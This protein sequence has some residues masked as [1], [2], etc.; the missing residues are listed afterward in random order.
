[1]AADHTLNG[2]HF[3]AVGYGV[4][5]P[6]PGG[7]PMTFPFTNDRWRA[8]SDFNA[9][10]KVWLRL[11]QNSATGNGGT[12]YGDS[13]GPNF[14]GSGANETS[15]IAAITVTGDAF[16]FSTNVDYRLDT[17]QARTFLQPFVL[18]P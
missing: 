13:G 8:V 3:T 2:T 17:P 6:T 5:E 1:M 9:L 14:L 18:L 7:G 16:C 15:M 12:C 4:H 11:S 10:T